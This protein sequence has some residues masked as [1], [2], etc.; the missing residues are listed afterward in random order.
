MLRVHWRCMRLTDVDPR[1]GAG[2][3]WKRASSRWAQRLGSDDRQLGRGSAGSAAENPP[4]AGTR[5]RARAAPPPSSG[6]RGLTREVGG[7]WGSPWGWRW[8]S[9][10]STATAS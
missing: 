1:G 10:G 3:R 9:W 4:R 7:R 5:A 2:S 8:R 6:V